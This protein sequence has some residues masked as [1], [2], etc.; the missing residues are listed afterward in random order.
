MAPRSLFPVLL[1][2]LALVGPD[3]VPRVTAAPQE[4]LVHAGMAN[5]SAA[6]P[7]GDR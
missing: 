1:L 7:V 4:A 6:V 5:A 2:V 3:A